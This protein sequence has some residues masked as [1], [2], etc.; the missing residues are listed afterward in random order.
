MAPTVL[1]HPA[2][3]HSLRET[4][5]MNPT[6]VRCAPVPRDRKSA[7][8]LVE[9]LVVIGIIAVLIGILLPTLQSARR[10]A[11]RT[12]CLAS[13]R[14]LHQAF[15]AYAVDFKGVWPMARMQFK[16]TAAPVNRELRWWDF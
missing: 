2:H 6:Q 16:V 1:P 3:I 4:H 5:P 12:K 7:F 13:L 9:L 15:C 10:Q 8:T 11:D 14:S